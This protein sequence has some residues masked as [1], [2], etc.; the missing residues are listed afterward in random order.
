MTREHV[1]KLLD[2]KQLRESGMKFR[3]IAE[4]YEFSISRARE[5]YKKAIKV[6][7]AIETGWDY[8]KKPEIPEPE[9]IRLRMEDARAY[10]ALWRRG[11]TTLEQL[12]ELTDK[13][14]LLTRNFGKRSLESVRRIYG[15]KKG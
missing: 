5:L 2:I 10:N 9:L 3:E 4:I 1:E 12:M 15:Y 8:T 13:Q 14:L 7:H 6:S 11:I